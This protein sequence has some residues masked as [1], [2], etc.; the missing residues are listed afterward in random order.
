MLAGKSADVEQPRLDLLQP[1]RIERKRVGGARD[2][3]LALAGSRRAP[4]PS[5]FLDARPASASPP[6]V[7]PTSPSSSP[8]SP[9]PLRCSVPPRRIPASLRAALALPQAPTTAPQHH[10]GRGV[11]V[12]RTRAALTLFSSA[13]AQARLPPFWPGVRPS[14]FTRDLAVHAREAPVRGQGVVLNSARTCCCPVSR[15]FW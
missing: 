13:S 7:G 10:P 12:S 9:A 4:P 15:W 1:R 3:V 11:L 14:Q 8:P 5:P 6:S 2:L